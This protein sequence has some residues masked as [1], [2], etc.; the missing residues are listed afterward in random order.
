MRSGECSEFISINQQLKAD[1]EMPAVKLPQLKFEY[2]SA[3]F[4]ICCYF[5]YTSLV[6][7]EAFT[8]LHSLYFLKCKSQL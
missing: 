2:Y 4:S 3:D 1:E 5:S 7:V 6:S 8:S